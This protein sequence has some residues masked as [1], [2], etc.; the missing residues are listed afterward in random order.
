MSGLTGGKVLWGG[1]THQFISKI[2]FDL[3]GIPNDVVGTNRTIR[4]PADQ[5]TRFSTTIHE[6]DTISDILV[7]HSTDPDLFAIPVL[8]QIEHGAIPLT[9]TGHAPYEAQRFVNNGLSYKERD[10]QNLY[11]SWG[12]HYLEDTGMPYHTTLDPIIQSTHYQIEDYIDRNLMKYEAQVRTAVPKPVKNMYIEGWNLA[13]YVNPYAY[14]MY[15]AWAKKDYRMLDEIAVETLKATVASV[16]GAIQNFN[17]LYNV[18]AQ[19]FG[20]PTV[21]VFSVPIVGIALAYRKEKHP[22]YQLQK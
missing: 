22:V 4:A 15:E 20:F 3:S 9:R 17:T 16:A 21:L 7:Q 11:L 6:G 5:D 2:A 10:L 12:I 14:L 19:P 8:W 1:N 18:V 13:E